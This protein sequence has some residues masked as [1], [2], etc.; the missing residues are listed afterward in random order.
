[1]IVSCRFSTALFVHLLLQVASMKRMSLIV[2]YFVNVKII[3]S[4][5][6]DTHLVES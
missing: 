1:M 4:R 2:D 6:R 5:H 3:E